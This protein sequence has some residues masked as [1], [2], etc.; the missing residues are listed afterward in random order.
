MADS[1]LVPSLPIGSC[2]RADTPVRDAFPP[3]EPMALDAPVS[4]GHDTGSG[5]EVCIVLKRLPEAAAAAQQALTT[6]NTPPTLFVR[7]ERLVKLTAEDAGV[8]LRAVTPA[9]LQ[10]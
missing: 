1:H 5:V 2:E 3:G 7:E 4:E 6:Y 9:E 10:C 8:S